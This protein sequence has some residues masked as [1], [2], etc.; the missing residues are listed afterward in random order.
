MS[1]FKVAFTKVREVNPHNNAERLEILTIYGFQVVASKGRYNV[2]DF[3]LYIPIDAVLP[4]DLE[5]L[6]F[7]EGSKI[8][9]HNS[10]VRQI[11]IR[12]FPSQGMTIDVALV[13]QLLKQRGLNADMDFKLETD[14]AE[15]LG[16]KKYEPPQPE[17]QQSKPGEKKRKKNN[18]NPLLH[19]YNG[20]D[21]LK[22]FPDRFTEDE[23]VVI[24][25]KLHGTNCRAGILPSPKPSLKHLVLALRYLDFGNAANE[26]KNLIL[27]LFGKLPKYEF[28]Y[29]SNNVELTNRAVDQNF[30]GENVYAKA[31]SNALLQAEKDR[32]FD[33]LPPT[34]KIHAMDGMKP[35]EVIYGEIIG[36]GLQKGYD[37][38]HKDEK[39]F[40][41]FDV[42]I[43][44]EDGT[45]R[46][47]NPEEVE[48]YAKERGFKMVP[49]LYTGKFNKAMVTELTKGNSV[50]CPEQKVREGVVV[51]SRNN[52]ND[53]Y[54]S[55]QK[56]ALKVISEAYLDGDNDD[57][58]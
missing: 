47:L 34:N 10:R 27:N 16:I 5:S 8:K 55:S 39:V 17:F 56:R 52:Y 42:K 48:A 35:M 26:A 41:L 28:C 31:L 44:N 36:A 11:R 43:M 40:V 22:W 21:N 13:K 29:G 37:Y 58:H 49:A 50:Y 53:P 19:S 51:K 57:F 24:Q 18:N 23:E 38:G 14:Y 6:V 54:C 12:N 1:E 4:S 25:E 2:G 45:F 15:L 32:M 30:Y 33:K 46:W 20:L 3:V 7:P 9:L